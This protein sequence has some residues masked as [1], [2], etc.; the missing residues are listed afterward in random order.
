MHFRLPDDSTLPDTYAIVACTTCGFVYADTPGNDE[1]YTRHYTCNSRYEDPTVATGSGTSEFDRERLADTAR[2]IATHVPYDA[3]VLDI[4]C[5]N[6]GLLLALRAIGFLDL[7]GMDL[8]TGCLE[9]LDALGLHAIQGG[10]GASMPKPAGSYDL[11]ILSHV[12]EHL[13][14]P[15]EALRS[16]CA[17]LSPT[18]RIYVET[19]DA[20]RYIDYPSVPF[21]Y[22]D[23]EHINHFDVGS[24]DYL[25]RKSG[26][27]VEKVGTKTL[28][29]MDSHPY[30]AA[31]G[32]IRPTQT[33]QLLTRNE[34]LA[35]AISR[36]IE[37]SQADDGLCAAARYAITSGRSIALWGAGSQAQRL[38]SSPIMSSANIVAVVDRD[39]NKQGNMLAGHPI[40]APEIGLV[41]L[42]A[43][44]LVVIAAALF[45]DNI[46]REYEALGL[47]YECVVN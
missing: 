33:E 3:R 14:D 25:A 12:L 11:I 31:Y 47:P 26:Y 4:G 30:P 13:L 36:Y 6:G 37:H 15:S 20:S 45:A 9:R 23:C 34:D 35:P 32:L 41:D 29:L 10:L 40:Q 21:Y 22:F 5:G 44:C 24:L 1:D 42:P 46:L 16:L 7:H 8:A 17:W 43:D 2:W 39:R 27:I 19:P 38:L 18:G 28:S